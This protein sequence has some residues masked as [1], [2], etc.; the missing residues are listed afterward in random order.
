MR[1]PWF[2]IGTSKPSPVYR[3]ASEPS[4]LHDLSKLQFELRQH[5]ALN[6]QY[7]FYPAFYNMTFTW[8]NL[9]NNYYTALEVI[10]CVVAVLILLSAVDDLFI[11]A[12]YW[13]RQVYRRVTSRQTYR[14]VTQQDLQ[15]RAEQ[16][17]AIM[18]PAWLEYDVIAPMIENMVKVLDYRNYVIFVGTYV[19]DMRTI[20]EV[21]RMRR[22]YKQ[23]RRVEVPHPGPTCK[24][25]C[26]N[27]IIQAIFLHE[28]KCGDQFAGVIL[29]DSEDVLHPLEL[30]FFNYLLPRKD[31]IQLPV[32][33]LE[34]KWSELVAG[35]YMDEFAESHAKDIVVRESLSGMV[36]S[37][38]VGTCFSRRALQALVNE[39]SNQP[40]NTDSLTEDY[41]IGARLASMGMQSIFARFPVQFTLKRRSW[42]GLGKER[43]VTVAMP[44][45]VREYFPDR[46]K[47]AYRQ[48]ARW[49]L[50]ISLQGWAQIGWKGSLATKYLLFRDRK[51]IVTTFVSILA[52][53]VLVQFIA[54]QIAEHFGAW[55][56][57]SQTLLTSLE[58]L[59]YVLH[60]NLI[61][62]GLRTVQRAYF[63]GR[64]YGP[65]H[66]VLSAPRMV[67]GNFINFMAVARAWKMFL[68]HLVFGKR[69]VWDK[70][71]H[72]FPSDDQLARERQRLGELLVSW[73]AI[74]DTDMEMAVQEHVESQIPLGRVLVA[75]GYIDE[76]TLAEAIAFQAELPR[77]ES[78]VSP[79]IPNTVS[80][81]LLVELSALPIGVDESGRPIIAVG[82]PLRPEAI[83]RLAAAFG[84]EP[85]Q[86]IA[87][88]SQVLA[89]LRLASG[90]TASGMPRQGQNST[91]LLGQLLVE[92]GELNQHTLDQAMLDYK[93]A[94]HGRIGDYLV[95][96][97]LVSREVVEE[98]VEQQMTLFKLALKV[99]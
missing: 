85:V 73:Q 46:F 39:N 63:V 17:L 62:L 37:A 2:W 59:P 75:R 58:W 38:G 7:A 91:Y 20:S 97:G 68:G 81:D 32:M 55:S 22:R 19:N 95:A 43:Q 67:V 56:P 26:L 18:V 69:L 96:N 94:Q 49:A 83:S 88:D 79:E 30:K 98:A 29:H 24:A 82:R 5:H 57:D 21:E 86:H 15:N 27:W 34:R 14:P 1:K 61:A 89:G 50:G 11:D 52:Y 48:K 12:W 36:P 77:V 66:A 71:M 72:D 64:I 44:L 28:K 92:N 16:P 4:S 60:A 3:E 84:K 70:T 78:A 53:I 10:T 65:V 23:L 51:G 42:F 54:F 93:P 13:V 47:T 80:L 41:D 90:Q 45:C 9:L 40:F 25:D 33:S 8:L 31:M 87:R 35:T 6:Q 74:T 76:D 99:A